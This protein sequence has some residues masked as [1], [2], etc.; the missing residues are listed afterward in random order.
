MLEDERVY[1][2]SAR[3]RMVEVG[4]HA[5]ELEIYAHVR[6]T[7]WLE[8]LEIREDLYLRILQEIEEAGTALVPRAQTTYLKDLDDAVRAVDVPQDAAVREPGGESVT[9]PR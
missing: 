1:D 2:N 4:R 6:T 5:I 7:A 3:R 9:R 8:F